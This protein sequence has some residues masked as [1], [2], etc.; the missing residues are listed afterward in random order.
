MYN[1]TGYYTITFPILPNGAYFQKIYD[2]LPPHNTFSFEIKAFAIDGFLPDD[3]FFDDFIISR[4][5]INTSTNSQTMKNNCGR[6]I[7]KDY[8]SFAIRIQVAHSAPTL[9]IKIKRVSSTS[10]FWTSMGYREITI[11]FSNSA[12]LSPLYPA[13]CLDAT[14]PTS[15][16]CST[17]AYSNSSCITCPGGIGICDAY[18]RT[19]SNLTQ[20]FS[21][22]PSCETCNGP[23]DTHCLS[24][25]WGRVYD[26]SKCVD[27]FSQMYQDSSK[28]LH[29]F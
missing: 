16:G 6:F 2:N 20:C 28:K 24:C 5:F 29:I 3:I 12:T 21:C 26:G 18:N 4:S 17:G 7:D 22:H 19:C 15:C 11:K 8:D 10:Y 25:A 23:A 13:F 9:S 27:E 14:Y 1:S